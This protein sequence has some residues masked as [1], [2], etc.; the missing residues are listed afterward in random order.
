MA[1]ALKCNS[2][3]GIFPDTRAPGS[4]QYF[5]ACPDQ[6]IDQPEQVD[7]HYNIVKPATR[8]PTPN[9]RNEILKPHPDNPGQLVMVSEGSGITEIN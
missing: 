1:K 8:K 9:P 7:E 2:C 5:H 3:G 4:I 6:I